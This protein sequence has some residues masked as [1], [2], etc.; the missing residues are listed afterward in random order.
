MAVVS[1]LFQ[2]KSFSLRRAG[3][4]NPGGILSIDGVA[5]STLLCLH[6]QKELDLRNDLILVWNLYSQILTVSKDV[7]GLNLEKCQ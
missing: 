2:V 5:R 3:S 7:K 6:R 4:A 1:E